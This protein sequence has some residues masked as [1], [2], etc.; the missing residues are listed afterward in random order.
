MAASKPHISQ[1]ELADRLGI[2]TRSVRDLVLKGLPKEG[3]GPSAKHPWPE[4]R[5][6]YNAYLERL[7]EE[8]YR[9]T[10]LDAL[11]ARKLEAD[12]RLAEIEVA[13]AEQEL[14]PFEMHERRLGAICDRLRGVLMTIP[15]KYLSAIQVSRTDLEAQSVGETIRDDTLRALQGVS[16]SIDDESDADAEVA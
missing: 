6:W 9:P 1:K 11:R 13:K 5:I 16:E 8:R 3:E 14:V 7:A 15:S 4:A 10:D 12:A 2:T